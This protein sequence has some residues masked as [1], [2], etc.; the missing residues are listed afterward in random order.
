MTQKCYFVHDY[1]SNDAIRSE[2]SESCSTHRQAV[3]KSFNSIKPD[4][5]T[6]NTQK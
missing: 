1:D 2:M 5:T 4:G 6:W 3:K